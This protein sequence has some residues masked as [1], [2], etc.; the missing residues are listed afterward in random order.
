[1][2]FFIVQNEKLWTFSPKL[3]TFC[4]L[5]FIEQ[6][7]H[8]S[9][10][11][12][13]CGRWYLRYRWPMLKTKAS[14]RYGRRPLGLMSG[15]GWPPIPYVW[16]TAHNYLNPSICGP[17]HASQM[18]INNNKCKTIWMWHE[19]W[20]F[21]LRGIEPQLIKLEFIIYLSL[22]EKMLLWN[23]WKK[24]LKRNNCCVWFENEYQLCR[25]VCKRSMWM[26]EWVEEDEQPLCGPQGATVWYGLRC[27]LPA[28]MW[29][30][31]PVT[32]Y[33]HHS[34]ATN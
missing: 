11:M 26:V 23:E 4:L 5:F 25:T 34:S 17:S 15:N 22:C 30:T 16:P 6:Q 12:N 32:H 7:I 21:Y 24:M 10:N 19:F 28:V 20:E 18:E 27:H 33:F 29:P 8:T 2:N 3:W 31:R 14:G 1:M 13:A 9:T